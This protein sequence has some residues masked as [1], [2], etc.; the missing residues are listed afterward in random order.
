MLM[1]TSSPRGVSSF[2]QRP[3]QG[4]CRRTQPRVR[5]RWLTPRIVSRSRQAGVAGELASSGNRRISAPIATSA[6]S[7]ASDAPEAVV[8]PAGEREV[9]IGVGAVEP[10]LVRIVEHRRIV[11]GR[12]QHASSPSCRPAPRLAVADGVDRAR[13]RSAAPGRRSAAARRSPV[14]SSEG[15]SRQRPQ[16]VGMAQQGEHAVADQVDRGLVAGDVQQD[17]ERR[18]AP[19]SI[20]RS[21]ASSATSSAD[22]R[23]SPRCVRRSSMTRG[24]YSVDLHARRLGGVEACSSAVGSSDAVSACDHVAQLVG[25]RRSA[26]RAAR[27]SP[28]TAPGRRAR[29]PAPS[30]PARRRRRARHR[31]TARCVGRSRSI[32]VGRERLADQS[33]QPGVIGRVEVEDRLRRPPLGHALADGARASRPGPGRRGGAVLSTS[34]ENSLRTQGAGTSS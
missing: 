10:Q 30:N 17:D 2:R 14:A 32:A 4:R 29:R 25:S 7:R 26:G 23:S 9:A 22:S 6:S 18:P 20:S 24:R 11:V 12:A 16:F 13:G 27:R 8:H 19:A 21:P 5:G 28:G 15:S 31:R 3:E 1:W 33:T 34:R